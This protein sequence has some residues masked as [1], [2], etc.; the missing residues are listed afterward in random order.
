MSQNRVA[1]YVRRPPVAR[2]PRRTASADGIGPLTGLGVALVLLA[3]CV[4]GSLLDL[5]LV[6]GPAWAVSALYVAS[7]GYTAYRVRGADWYAAL[8]APPLAFALA[9]IL[10]A[11]LMPQSFGPGMLGLA[12]TTFELLATKAKALFLGTALSAVVLAVRRVR[13]RL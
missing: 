9:M 2:A 7:C 12:A 13:S 10:L 5:L 11:K 6:G 4:L 3:G 8:V 1:P